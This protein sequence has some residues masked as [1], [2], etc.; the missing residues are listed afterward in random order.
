MDH[1][2]VIIVEDVKLELK[3]TEEI[4]R[5]EIPEAEIIG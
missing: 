4:F 3:G 1:F 2:K 5:N